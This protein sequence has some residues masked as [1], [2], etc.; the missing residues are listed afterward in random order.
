MAMSVKDYA[1]YVDKIKS[2]DIKKGDVVWFDCPEF[3]GDGLR[4]F[5]VN[6]HEHPVRDNVNHPSHYTP[7]GIECIDALRS[8]MPKEEFSGFCRGNAIK[9]LWRSNKKH[10]VEDLKK[11]QVYLNWLI[12]NESSRT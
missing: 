11:A 6:T 7:D 5:H 3:D 4:S 12:E 9:Y 2:G 1:D 8:L 10:Q